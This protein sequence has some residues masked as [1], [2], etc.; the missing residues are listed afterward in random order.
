MLDIIGKSTKRRI[1]IDDKAEWLFLCGRDIFGKSIVRAD[2]KEGF[3][4]IQ[5]KAGETL[6]FGKITDDISKK[7]KAVIKN[8]LDR[9]DFLRRER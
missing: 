6:G 7:N 1:I 3:A 2:V 8:K 9:G 4:I 5:N